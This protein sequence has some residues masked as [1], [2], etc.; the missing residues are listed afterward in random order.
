[1]LDNLIYRQ[2]VGLGLL[3][4]VAVVYAS[5]FIF[6]GPRHQSYSPV[7]R[8]YQAP[9]TST[10]QT[11]AGYRVFS[12]YVRGSNAPYR[13]ISQAIAA[14]DQY[15]TR[16]GNIVTYR[17]MTPD[18]PTIETAIPVSYDVTTQVCGFPRSP[19]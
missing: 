8:S 10:V 16:Q 12:C 4:G 13:T 3:A 19:Q 11:T 15:T 14:P 1:M 7:A 5:V 18:H 6:G 17:I 9:T 2:K